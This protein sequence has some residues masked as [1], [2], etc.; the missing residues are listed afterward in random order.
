VSAD[1][2]G[3]AGARWR[4]QLARPVS[5]RLGEPCPDRGVWIR[6]NNEAGRQDPFFNQDDVLHGI[7]PLNDAVSS[8]PRPSCPEPQN[9]RLGVTINVMLIPLRNISVGGNVPVALRCPGCRQVGTFEPLPNVQDIKVVQDIKANPVW[10]GQ[11]ACPNPS[12]RTHA[13]IVHDLSG[14]VVASYPKQRIDFDPKG[15]PVAI[16]KTFEEAV[17]CF[18]EDLHVAGAIMVRRT[19]EELCEDKNATGANLK[20]RMSALQSVVVLPQGLLQAL[21]DLRLLGNDAAHVEA[22]SYDAIGK[23]ELSLALELTKEILK[24]VYQLD[25][26]LSRLRAL[27]KPAN[28]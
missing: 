1:A 25:D 12:C 5:R 9:Q 18:A 24:A 20:T 14:L 10:T 7:D 21:D 26:L 4:R 2:G 27:K 17:T 6:G 16:V 13:F 3:G 11:R 19:L 8:R 23:D 28:P 22:K 15:I